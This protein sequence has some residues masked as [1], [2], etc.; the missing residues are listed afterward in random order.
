M[1]VAAKPDYGVVLKQ[2]N[3]AIRR[4]EMYPPGHP[5]SM[6][7]IEKPFSVLQ[8]VLKTDGHFIISRV[9]DKI[10]VNGKNIEGADL[11][12]RFLEE[13]QN[14]DIDSVSI[15]KSLTREDLSKFL[16]FF[17]NISSKIRSIPL[18]W[19]NSATSWWRRTRWW[20]NPAWWKE[21]I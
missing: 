21:L 5:A 19:T 2:M 20:S 10:V 11:L 12:K 7:A 4:L 13:F 6:Q 18:R 14:Q 17:V 9:E 16:N 8:E 15:A 3:G 1:V